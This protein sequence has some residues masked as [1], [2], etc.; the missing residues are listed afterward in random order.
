MLIIFVGLFVFN[1]DE[2]IEI[3]IICLEEGWEIVGSYFMVGKK[4]IYIIEIYLMGFV[5]LW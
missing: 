4:L 5:M 1:R 3:D 2:D